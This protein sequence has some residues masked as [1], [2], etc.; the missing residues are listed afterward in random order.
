M[1]YLHSYV[2]KLKLDDPVGATSVHLLTVY[3]TICVG[4]LEELQV[5]PVPTDCSLEVSL[6][7][8]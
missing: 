7:E 1:P 5:Y 4:F 8:L 3:F 2:C 6:G